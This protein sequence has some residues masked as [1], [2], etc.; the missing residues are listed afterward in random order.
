MAGSLPFLCCSEP[1]L[2]GGARGR[3]GEAL[4]GPAG[5]GPVAFSLQEFLC[6][7]RCPE[8]TRSLWPLVPPKWG[9]SFAACGYLPLLAWGPREGRAG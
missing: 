3:W 9:F 4:G 8:H 5:L 6:G 2:G 1:G 7:W